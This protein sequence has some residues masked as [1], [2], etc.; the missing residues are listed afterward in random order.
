MRGTLQ[1]GA[2]YFQEE[3]AVLHYNHDRAEDLAR[4]HQTNVIIKTRFGRELQRKQA[5]QKESLE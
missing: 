5:S 4:K 3:R 1:I 2:S